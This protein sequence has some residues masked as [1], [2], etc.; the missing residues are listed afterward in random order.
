MVADVYFEVKTKRN[1]YLCRSE[2]FL[3]ISERSRAMN[4]KVTLEKISV[5][6]GRRR[7]KIN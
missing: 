2:G 1:N 3:C 7:L 4:L 5:I 6:S